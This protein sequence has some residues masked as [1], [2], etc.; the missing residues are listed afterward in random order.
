[1]DAEIER[2]TGKKNLKNFTMRSM[3]KFDD[4]FTK[5]GR[6][7]SRET[8]RQNLEVVIYR[9]IGEKWKISSAADFF[10]GFNENVNFRVAFLLC[11]V[12]IVRLRE[13]NLCPYCF[14]YFE[15]LTQIYKH[16]KKW[17]T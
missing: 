16:L 3:T 17:H 15:N 12:V 6:N 7:V 9:V 4:Y 11:N 5:K 14:K 1:M 13:K 8:H 10:N 2:K